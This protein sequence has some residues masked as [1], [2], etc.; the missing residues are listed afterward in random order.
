MII[1]NKMKRNKTKYKLIFLKSIKPHRSTL[2]ALESARFQEPANRIAAKFVCLLKS[3]FTGSLFRSPLAVLDGDHLAYI[4]RGSPPEPF[5]C[6]VR[7]IF[8]KLLP[9]DSNKVVPLKASI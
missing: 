7:L 8:N 5:D 1:K 3:A 2:P 9:S 6:S 4:L